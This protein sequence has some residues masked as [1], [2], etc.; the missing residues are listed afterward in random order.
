M[1]CHAMHVTSNCFPSVAKADGPS[2]SRFLPI[3]LRSSF[4]A[5][6]MG[7]AGKSGNNRHL[8]LDIGGLNRTSSGPRCVRGEGGQEMKTRKSLTVRAARVLL[9][10]AVLFGACPPTAT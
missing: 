10:G 9:A 3:L 5:G 8:R 2:G 1:N 7:K 4:A 6:R